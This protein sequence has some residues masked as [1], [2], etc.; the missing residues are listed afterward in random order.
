MSVMSTQGG[1]KGWTSSGM[2][3]RESTEYDATSF[4]G[5]NDTVK[6]RILPQLRSGSHTAQT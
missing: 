5:I 4:D 1:M 3:V 6:G 2:L